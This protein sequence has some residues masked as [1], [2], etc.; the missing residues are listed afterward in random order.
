MVVRNKNEERACP[1]EKEMVCEVKNDNRLGGREIIERRATCSCGRR[2]Q[3]SQ[4]AGL[5][6]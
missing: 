1:R 4:R 2:G 3:V 6:Q 5:E